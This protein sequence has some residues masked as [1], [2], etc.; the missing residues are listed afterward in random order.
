MERWW[1]DILSWSSFSSRPEEREQ[2]H[3]NEHKERRPG[4]V[5]THTEQKH[6]LRQKLKHP[7][8]FDHNEFPFTGLII[9]DPA[10]VKKRE[11][12][13]ENWI[14]ARQQAGR[15]STNHDNHIHR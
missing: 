7:T 12:I 13:K 4:E 10:R 14:A 11:E 3:P 15:K 9:L 5:L 6:M 2:S 1:A 8:I